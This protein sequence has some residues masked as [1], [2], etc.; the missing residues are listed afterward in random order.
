MR[1]YVRG[2]CRPFFVARIG[3]PTG[4]LRCRQ[5]LPLQLTANFLPPSVERRAPSGFEPTYARLIAAQT[6]GGSSSFG[7]RRAAK[8]RQKRGLQATT[9]VSVFINE[10]ASIYS[11]PP[12]FEQALYRFELDENLPA[13]TFAQVKVG[14]GDRRRA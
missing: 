13:Q 8:T 4:D 10:S 14:E 2:D 11:Q 12:R 1:A 9:V 5:H 7:E 6:R 3:A